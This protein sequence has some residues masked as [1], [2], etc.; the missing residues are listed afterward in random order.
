MARR[1][2]ALALPVGTVVLALLFLPAASAGPGA[3]FRAS[4]ATG[5]EQGNGRSFFPAISAD[6]R[7]V[8]FYSDASNLVSGDTNA[9][10][11]VFVNDR[12]TGETARMSIDSIRRGGERRQLRARDQRGWALRDLLLGRFEP[13]RGRHERC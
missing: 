6:G 4:V 3:T 2:G 8:A 9:A 7:F 1:L 11:D 12:Q 13:G 5:G 10:R